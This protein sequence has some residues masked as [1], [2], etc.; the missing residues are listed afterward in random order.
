[1]ANAIAIN[2]NLDA[3]SV[4]NAYYGNVSN[5]TVIYDVMGTR[6]LPITSKDTSNM[7]VHTNPL[8]KAA[9]EANEAS[10]N[11]NEY[12]AKIKALTS[13]TGGPEIGRAHV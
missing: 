6:L 7:L 13:Q 5:E 2:E 12:E 9:I 4:Y 3:D 11:K 10:K 1:M 8:I